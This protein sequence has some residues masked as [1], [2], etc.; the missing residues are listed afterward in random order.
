V[1]NDS[2]HKNWKQ[3]VLH[4]A[5]TKTDNHSGSKAFT[6]AIA[7]L[8]QR[9]RFQELIFNLSTQFIDLPTSEVDPQIE[10]SLKHIVEFL[11]IDRSSLS[12][13]SKDLKK[14]H[15]THS[16]AV[17][18]FEASP[19]ITVNQVFPYLTGKILRGENFVFEN[20]SELPEDAV[21]EKTYCQNTGLKSHLSIPVAIGGTPQ[22]VI[23]FS[24]FRTYRTWPGEYIS[25]L[26]R[27]GE[28]F[29]QTIY[30]KQTEGQLREI[31]E[32]QLQLRGLCLTY[33]RSLSTCLLTRSTARLKMPYGKSVNTW[34]WT[35]V[36]CGSRWLLIGI[37]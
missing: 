19:R 36:R 6:P 28:V 32:K 7:E 35:W 22:C 31:Q 21:V 23:S 12:E 25:Q 34:I 27:L 33:L 10:R 8:E 24:T 30:R 18:G 13:I 2:D 14:L 3:E 5:E 26:K 4:P 1:K 9:L 20:P 16:Y 29:A 11:G 37:R 17:P 15:T